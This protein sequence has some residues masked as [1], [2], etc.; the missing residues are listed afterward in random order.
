MNDSSLNVFDYA[1]LIKDSIELSLD[2]AETSDPKDLKTYTKEHI[3]DSPVIYDLS[4][5]TKSYDRSM[6]PWE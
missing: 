6:L 5:L 4:D 3:I 1:K 2:S